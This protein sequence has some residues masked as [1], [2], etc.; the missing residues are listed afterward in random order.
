MKNRE[1]TLQYVVIFL[2]V[3]D[4]IIG[5]GYPTI[6]SLFARPFPADS[7]TIN[8]NGTTDSKQTVVPPVPIS[9]ILPALVGR[10]IFLLPLTLLGIFLIPNFLFIFP[11]V[12]ASYSSAHF[13]PHAILWSLAIISVFLTFR[14]S[15]GLPV[16]KRLFYTYL[17][18][19][20]IAGMGAVAWSPILSG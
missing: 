14:Y 16:W 15:K 1:R 9:M 2:L 18:A 3:L 13:L 20:L 19:A 11:Q 6:S 10:F 4:F 8:P 5:V 17:I 12:E 7:V